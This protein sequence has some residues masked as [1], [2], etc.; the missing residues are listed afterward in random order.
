MRQRNAE[1]ASGRT[2]DPDGDSVFAA[3]NRGPGRLRVWCGKEEIVCAVLF[4]QCKEPDLSEE[5]FPG[6]SVVP[7]VEFQ[8][9]CALRNIVDPFKEC[10]LVGPACADDIRP[11]SGRFGV[12]VVESHSQACVLPV[13]GAADNS[14]DFQTDTEEELFGSG[15]YGNPEGSPVRSRGCDG[16]RIG[17]F[18][19]LRVSMFPRFERKQQVFRVCGKRRKKQN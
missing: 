17:G 9:D 19:N 3:G 10:F 11:G 6:G 1:C 2:G 14:V 13:G 12:F 4:V 8:R 7:G 5:G 18:D 16:Y 15:G